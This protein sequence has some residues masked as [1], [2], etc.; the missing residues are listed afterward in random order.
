MLYIYISLSPVIEQWNDLNA[1]LSNFICFVDLQ[2]WRAPAREKP[3]LKPMCQVTLGRPSRPLI[4]WFFRGK[5]TIT[6][7]VVGFPPIPPI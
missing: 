2:S 1:F 7:L 3:G 6:G 4:Q 5:S